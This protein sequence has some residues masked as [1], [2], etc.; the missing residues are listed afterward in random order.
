MDFSFDGMVGADAIN[1]LSAVTLEPVSF[2]ML[3]SCPGV[4]HQ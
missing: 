4:S 3:N 1:R 2:F